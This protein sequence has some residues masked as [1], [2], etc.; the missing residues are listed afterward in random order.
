MRNELLP[1]QTN[2]NE[3]AASL[4]QRPPPALPSGEG[5]HLQ[6]EYWP[7]ARLRPAARNPRLHS[8]QQIEEVA[9]SIAE[10]GFVNPVLIDPDGELIAGHC[11]VLAAERAGLDPVPAI[12]LRH[13]TVVQKEALRVADNQLG[14]NASWDEPLLRSVLLDLEEENFDIGVLGF[15]SH[16]LDDILFR[17]EDPEEAA[18]EL[19]QRPE[20][21]V[22]KPGDL[23]CCGDHRL[24]CGDATSAADVNR[25]LES[26]APSLMVTD[27]PYGV[28]YEPGWREEAGLGRVRQRGKVSHD[29]RADWT[30]AYQ[31]FPGDVIYVWHA[32]LHAA[33]VAQG[34]AAAGF[35]LRSQMIWVKQHFAL[36][37]GHYHWG[38]EPAWF[39][40]R[41]GKQANWCG[42]RGQSTVWEIPNLNPFSGGQEESTGHGTQKPVELMKRPILNHTASGDSVYDPFLGSGTTM[43]AAELTRR[44]C[45]ALEIEPAYVDMA[46]MRCQRLTGQQAVRLEDGKPF[47]AVQKEIAIE[48]NSLE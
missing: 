36:S 30:E 17:L 12:V 27:P 10:F 19:V 14:L 32:G 33:E 4:P 22:T 11:R 29:D 15:D 31:L 26:A 2:Q 46:V 6:V 3:T 39:A 28:C 21:V 40:V 8:P 13:L 18:D 25:L 24:L 38:H 20:V 47:D 44:K 42:D 37:R 16:E 5:L 48:E 9:R 35:E 41:R 1:H 45:Y 43:I 7:L 23:W 34:L